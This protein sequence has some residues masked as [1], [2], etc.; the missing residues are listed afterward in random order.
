[1][2]DL[3]G[4]FTADWDAVSSAWEKEIDISPAQSRWGL[5]SGRFCRACRTYALGGIQWGGVEARPG[6]GRRHAVTD[7]KM[8]GEIERNP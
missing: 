6:S 3:L 7:V 4:K 2:G 1:M 5:H 8:N